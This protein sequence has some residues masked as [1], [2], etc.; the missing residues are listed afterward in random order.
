MAAHGD[1]REDFLLGGGLGDG[2]SSRPMDP[3]Q[4]PPVVLYRELVTLYDQDAEDLR[5]A[6]DLAC[7]ALVSGSKVPEINACDDE[8]Q[9]PRDG[10]EGSEPVVENEDERELQASVKKKF[11]EAME[12]LQ[13]THVPKK[14]RGNLPKEATDMF[15]AWFSEH[16][17]HPYPTDEEK[18][19]LA[20][21]TNVRRFLPFQSPG[22]LR[23]S[24]F[25]N[26]QVS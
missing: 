25:Y 12:Q 19:E 20:I 26:P 24:S 16:Q 13:S 8:P 6:V 5:N 21:K 11:I 18:K 10:V 4:Q 22:R 2:A 9:E 17:D 15:R 7:Q 14:R 1:G 3:R 23:L